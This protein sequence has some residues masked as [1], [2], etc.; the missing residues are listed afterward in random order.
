MSVEDLNKEQEKSMRKNLIKESYEWEDK[1]LFSFLIGELPLEREVYRHLGKDLTSEQLKQN[2]VVKSINEIIDNYNSKISISEFD[3]EKI[4]SLYN[5]LDKYIDR[6][7]TYYSDIKNQ[8][9]FNKVIL[10][11]GPGGIGKSQ[12]LYEFSNKLKG[13]KYLCIYGKYCNNLNV[14][15]FDEINNLTKKSKFYFV[16]DAINEFCENDRKELIEFFK[17][18]K[19]NKNLRIIVSYRNYSMSEDEINLIKSI[20]DEEETFAGVSAEDALQKISQKYNLDLSVYFRLLYD[21][22]PLHLKMIINSIDSNEL[23]TKPLNPVAKGTYIYEHFIKRVLTVKEWNLT[24]KI[25]SKMLETKEKSISIIDMRA[26]LDFNFDDYVI[27]MKQNQFLASY[28]SNG[29]E[30]FYFINET[31][32]DYLVARLLFDEISDKNYF[33]IICYINEIVRVFYTIHI[34]IILLLFDKYSNNVNL[35]LK[36]IINSEL[37]NHLDLAVFNETIFSKE[38]LKK[39]PEKIKPQ[40]SIK[41]IL[42]TAGGNENNPFNCVNYL[43]RL[44]NNEVLKGSFNYTKY[45]KKLI[46]NRLKMYVQSISKFDYDDHY[47]NEKIYFSLWILA[48]PD[49]VLRALAEKLIFEILNCNN[50]YISRL[51]RF[52]KNVDDGYIHESIIHVLSSLK[53]GNKE[54]EKFFKQVNNNVM[55]NI[56]ILYYINIYLYEEEDYTKYK[57]INLLNETDNKKDPHICRFLS[58]VFYANKYDYDFLGFNGYSD[59]IQFTTKFLDERKDKILKVNKY[60]KDNYSC[61]DTIDC[62][63]SYYF[64]K[65]FIDGKFKIRNKLIKFNK[66]YMAWQKLFKKYLK[67]YNIKIKDLDNLVV[68][69]EL[70]KGL[71]YKLLD[72]SISEI[73]GSLTCNYFTDQFEIYSSH[74]GYQQNLYNMYDEK[75]ELFYPISVYNEKVEVLDNKIM[76]KIYLPEIKDLNW[77]NDEKIGMK[78]I[79]QIINP[80]EYD[81]ED[82]LLIYGKFRFDEKSNNHYGAE[83]ID[84]YI[85]NFAIN[86]N[87]NLTFNPN[88]DRLYTIE[89]KKFVGNI[90]DI[91][92]KFYSQTTSMNN[93]NEYRDEFLSTDFNI[94]PTTII[95]EFHLHYNKSTSSWNNE[96]NEEVVLVNNNE[97]IWYKNGATG[98]I[99]LKKKYYDSLVKKY[100]CK[101]FAFTEKFRPETGYSKES[102]LQIQIN[103]K[104]DIL[105]YKHYKSN[106]SEDSDNQRCHNCL[107]YKHHQKSMKN[108]KFKLI[109]ILD[110][111][112]Y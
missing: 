95:N 71:V 80:I 66:I 65:M 39:I 34:P 15:I 22:N 29:I 1:N 108:S 105:S 46:R 35:A 18:S 82:W 41:D 40:L 84:T 11:S 37:Y 106:C 14:S 63:D 99:Y 36:I 12:F 92:G 94:P 79:L 19:N 60:I 49:K 6:Y 24:K 86:E 44:L 16:I 43:N 85:I 88:M 32:T 42:L 26:I 4:D 58:R 101:Y 31:L 21:N 77:V 89:T 62:C 38:N 50:K 110:D 17:N 56:K 47:L 73:T 52:Y 67:T 23:K 93:S 8:S 59:K 96:H 87:Y 78:N 109:K 112:E 27:K 51:I 104:D 30:Y 2:D 81:H 64:K 61:L 70:E 25:I 45:E 3:Y 74:K 9:I 68:Y 100:K 7:M 91:C 48:I 72:I 107:I 55:I 75:S 20:S 76:K 33:E 69:E 57:K 53:R 13:N 102:A 90:Y 98:T 5:E 83:W 28:T 54:I 10:I 97:G 111:L 103:S